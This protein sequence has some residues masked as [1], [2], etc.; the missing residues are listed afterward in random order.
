NITNQSTTDEKA[1]SPQIF[2]ARTVLHKD[3]GGKTRMFIGSFFFL[4]KRPA[5][6]FCKLG[7]F[8]FL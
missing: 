3:G 5:A 4:L 7:A 1:Y 2:L 6:A 8:A